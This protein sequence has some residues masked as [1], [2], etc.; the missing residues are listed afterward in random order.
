MIDKSAITL[1]A[2]AMLSAH[3]LAQS[4]SPVAAVWAVNDGEKVA[5]DDL[6]NPNKGGIRLG[7]DAYSPVRRAQ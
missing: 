3:A 2:A 5:R 6:A 1:L 7:R 4:A